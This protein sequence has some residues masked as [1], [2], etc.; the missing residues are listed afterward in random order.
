M[1]VLIIEKT[2]RTRLILF[3]DAVDND[4]FKQSHGKARMK[5][6]R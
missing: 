6:K 5:R 3:I 2:W 1:S 4:S